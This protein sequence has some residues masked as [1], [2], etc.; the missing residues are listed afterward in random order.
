MRKLILF[1]FCI[2]FFTLSCKKGFLEEKPKGS[3][4]PQEFYKNG[5]DLN[6]ASIALYNNLNA[7]FNQLDGFAPLW[8][9]DDVTVVRS[10]NKETWSDYDIFQPVSS[11]QGA[12]YF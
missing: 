1:F 3:V 8:G 2:S 5:S 7:A 12:T 11:N 6:L 10:G 4:T 9:G